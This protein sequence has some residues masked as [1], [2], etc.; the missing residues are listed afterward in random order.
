MFK[1]SQEDYLRIIFLLEKKN[2]EHCVKSVDIANALKISKPAVSKM[3]KKFQQDNL[4]ILKPYSKIKLT[5]KGNRQA[6]KL[7]FK[8]QVIEK[9]LK[10]VLHLNKKE[11]KKETHNLEHAFS[12]L[13]IKKLDNFLNRNNF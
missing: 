7:V 10:N 4:I 12:N 9:F 5:L 8:Y 13:T 6:Q 2:K 1:Q 11:I 3:L